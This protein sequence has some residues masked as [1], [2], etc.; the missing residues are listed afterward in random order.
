MDLDNN[1]MYVAINNTW[2]ASGDP[3]GNSGGKAITAVASTTNGVYHFGAGD[4]S[5]GTPAFQSNFGNPVAA[6][7]SGNADGNGYGNFEYAPPSGFYALCTKNLAEY[8]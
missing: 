6:P 3:A 7:S 2:Q 5:S 4:A 1:K 8:G